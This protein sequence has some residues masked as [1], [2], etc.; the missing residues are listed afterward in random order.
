[1][2]WRSESWDHLRGFDM[3]TKCPHCNVI[4]KTPDEYKGKEIKCPT[5]K[6][7]FVATKFV[8]PPSIEKPGTGPKRGSTSM[9]KTKKCPF[10]GEEIQSEATKCRFCGEWLGKKA[11]KKCKE[12]GK[13]ISSKAN[14]C[15]NCG[16]RIRKTP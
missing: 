12:C 9:V 11:L 4:F 3:E 7:S 5:C 2:H 14:K 15:P 10:C 1:M 8:A 13:P 6:Q 16:A